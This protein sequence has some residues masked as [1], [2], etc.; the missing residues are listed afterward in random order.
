[1]T[2]RTL[3]FIPECEEDALTLSRLVE[4]TEQTLAMTSNAPESLGV[5]CPLPA[6][7]SRGVCVQLR[8]LRERGGC[9]LSGL[10]VAWGMLDPGGP[11]LPHWAGHPEWPV[12]HPKNTEPGTSAEL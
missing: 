2:E 4:E 11:G 9:E 5:G 8:G 1:M 10:F 6:S 3:C 12:G 7:S